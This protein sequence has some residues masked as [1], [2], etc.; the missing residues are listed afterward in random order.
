MSFATSAAD[1]PRG[2]DG[3][4]TGSTG[5]GLT[6]AAGGGPVGSTGEGLTGSTGGGFTGSTGEGLTGSTGGGFTGS[7]DGGFGG[8]GSS[9]EG[10][11]QETLVSGNFPLVGP[12]FV[13]MKT[14]TRAAPSATDTMMMGFVKGE[15]TVRLLARLE[16]LRPRR[17]LNSFR[18]RLA[19][20]RQPLC[21][22]A[23]TAGTS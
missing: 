4:F 7:T 22:P 2:W 15:A 20:S 3:G 13:A 5:G 11:Y 17:A 8:A 23:P 9:G 21:Q 6:G 14:A 1:K 18:R 10:S 12:A 19:I 16:I